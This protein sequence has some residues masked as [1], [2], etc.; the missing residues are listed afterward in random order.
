MAGSLVGT[1]YHLVITFRLASIKETFSIP[2]KALNTALC[3][4]SR[5]QVS[6]RSLSHT[7]IYVNLEEGLD[8]DAHIIDIPPFCAIACPYQRS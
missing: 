3:Q 1:W 2:L 5:S 6:C 4:S 7:F 8:S